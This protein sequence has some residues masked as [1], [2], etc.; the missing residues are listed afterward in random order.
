MS[1]QWNDFGRALV[2]PAFEEEVVPCLRRAVISD[3]RRE[4]VGDVAAFLKDALCPT[5]PDLFADGRQQAALDAARDRFTTPMAQSMLDHCEGALRDGDAAA[6]AIDKGVASSLRERARDSSH[7]IEAYLM[8]EENVATAKEAQTRCES[9][10]PNTDWTA[11]AHEVQNGPQPESNN[12]A[13]ETDRL[14]H[15]PPKAQP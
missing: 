15:G 5:A 14:E 13:S 11:L 7:S 2:R 4:Q 10:F 1:R 8:R 6:D 3:A 9:L 12:S